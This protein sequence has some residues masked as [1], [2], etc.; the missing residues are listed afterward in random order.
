M[1]IKLYD[2]KYPNSLGEEYKREIKEALAPI[3]HKSFKNK[4]KRSDIIRLLI[5]TVLSY[6][7]PSEFNSAI[8]SMKKKKSQE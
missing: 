7:L 3:L 5:S 8:L 2:D 1:E 4:I 6:R